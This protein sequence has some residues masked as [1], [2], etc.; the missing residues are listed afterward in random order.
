MVEV[1]ANEGWGWVVVIGAFC[2]HA[3]TYGI[4]YSFGIIFIALEEIFEGSK[5][6]IAWIPSLTTGLLHSSGLLA[7]ILVNKFG[8]RIVTIVGGITCTI[9]YVLSMFAPNIYYLYLTMGVIA[10]CGFGMVFMPAVLIVTQYFTRLRSVACGIALS[11][12]GI[13]VFIF[14][15]VLK[16]LL[17]DYSLKGTLLILSAITLNYIP[18]GF[19]FLPLSQKQGQQPVTTRQKYD[20]PDEFDSL[21]DHDGSGTDVK[22]KVLMEKDEPESYKHLRAID[23]HGY[24]GYKITL[25]AN[26]SEKVGDIVEIF[27]RNEDVANGVI[28]IEQCHKSHIS[29]STDTSG[30]LLRKYLVL[31]KSKKFLLFFVSQFLFI[32]GFYLPFIFIPDKAKGLGISENSSAWVAS[33]IGII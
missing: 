5:T 19:V 4:I 18:C 2:A 3:I 11:G 9:G 17:D 28:V 14:S 7:S 21:M 15:P 12:C 25:T 10:G 31:L 22:D 30:S 8:C 20:N 13:G 26:C 29:L 23:R 32:F 1:R 16:L 33:V 27:D 24:D 6:E